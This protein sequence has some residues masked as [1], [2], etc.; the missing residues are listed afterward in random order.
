MKEERKVIKM[1]EKLKKNP[2]N[3]GG[4]LTFDQI[5]RQQHPYV[6]FSRIL[7]KL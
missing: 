1:R 2:P 4:E 6:E 3:W 7:V 5:L